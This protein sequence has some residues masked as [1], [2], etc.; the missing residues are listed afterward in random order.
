MGK[1]I[2]TAIIVISVIVAVV[3]AVVIY[4]VL[5]L[6]GIIQKQRG[7]I[8][9]KASDAVGRKVDVQDIHAS[10]GWGVIADL[11][12]VTIADD[13][14]FSQTPF[15]QAADVYA[16]V[17]LMPLLS[18][19]VDVEQVSLKQP[20][21]H[22]IRNQRGQLNVSS[23][24]KSKPA[25]GESCGSRAGRAAAGDRD[26]AAQG[27]AAYPGRRRRDNRRRVRERWAKFRSRA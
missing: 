1:L 14:N 23:I 7:L 26:A 15:V 11:R 21:V 20:V 16:R 22:I 13:P 2:R 5:N 27:R 24:G 17:A 19:R 6:N 25:T 9:T 8:L 10:L 3:A 12:G 4:A 18:H